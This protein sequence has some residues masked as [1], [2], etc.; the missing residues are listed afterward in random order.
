MLRPKSE[1]LGIVRAPDALEAL[2]RAASL[3][4][5]QP[6]QHCKLMITK[7]EEYELGRYVD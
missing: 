7:I 5:I 3:F 2:H 1:H 4:R 6:A